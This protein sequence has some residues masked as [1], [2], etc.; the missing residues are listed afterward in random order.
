M[1]NYALYF[2]SSKA[3]IHIN[4]GLKNNNPNQK[5]RCLPNFFDNHRQ[6]RITAISGKIVAQ[7]PK[8][9]FIAFLITINDCPQVHV[10]HINRKIIETI[11]HANGTINNHRNHFL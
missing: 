5:A 2:E 3:M 1:V 8:I 6:R 10:V 7:I 11:I 4:I 9:Q